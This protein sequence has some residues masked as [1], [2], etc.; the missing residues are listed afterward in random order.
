MFQHN[1]AIDDHRVGDLAVFL[2]GPFNRGTY[3]LLKA[4]ANNSSSTIRQVPEC[5]SRKAGAPHPGT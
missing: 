5:V 4:S 3:F 2:K 1:P